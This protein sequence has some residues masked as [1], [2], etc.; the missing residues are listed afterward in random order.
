MICIFMSRVRLRLG[1]MPAGEE[2]ILGSGIQLLMNMQIRL[3]AKI[4]CRN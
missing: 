1:L 2:V 3:S 4:K